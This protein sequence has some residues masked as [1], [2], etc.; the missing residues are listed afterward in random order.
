MPAATETSK[1]DVLLCYNN[2]DVDEVKRLQAALGRY[3]IQ[4]WVDY[5]QLKPGSFWREGVKLGL[6]QSEFVIVIL[7]PAGAG[8]SQIDEIH[9]IIETCRNKHFIPVLLPGAD[10]SPLDQIGS[11]GRSYIQASEHADEQQVVERI[12]GV[13][14]PSAVP[15]PSGFGL[16]RPLKPV[17]RSCFLAPQRVVQP[18]LLPVFREVADSLQCPI[19]QDA[20]KTLP[21]FEPDVLTGVA[22]TSIVL[23][24]GRCLDGANHLDPA[25]GHVLGIA[26]AYGKPII[27]VMD[28][29]RKPRLPTFTANRTLDYA[30][31]HADAVSVLKQQLRLSIM[32]V[33]G[34]LKYPLMLSPDLKDMHVIFHGALRLTPAQWKYVAQ[35]VHTSRLLV[36]GFFTTGHHLSALSVI[37]HQADVAEDDGQRRCDGPRL[38]NEFRTA[39]HG[40]YSRHFTNRV[41]MLLQLWFERQDHLRSIMDQLAASAQG[42]VGKAFGKARDF[43]A[44]MGNGIDRFRLV[45]EN[46]LP[47]VPNP[48]G[49][50]APGQSAWPFGP[51]WYCDQLL[52]MREYADEVVTNALAA[53]S[54]FLPLLGHD[55]EPIQGVPSYAYDEQTA[56]AFI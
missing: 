24:D 41:V 7:G 31:N 16:Y 56:G 30:S 51:K 47:K 55:A 21:G 5:D 49:A 18:D 27:M 22:N 28:P 38:W 12:V 40:D 23:A 14:K 1:Y 53:I 3:G 25:V 34:S 48:V 46:F 9:Y 52:T 43:L 6:A 37:P 4:C 10:K 11:L 17:L 42:E 13:V 19:V 39:F 50:T 54:S 45:H 26:R 33:L 15:M 35:A 20:D 44:L 2:V 32:E 29:Q 8:T 36:D